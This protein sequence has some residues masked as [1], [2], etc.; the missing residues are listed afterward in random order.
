MASE[1]EQIK[2]VRTAHVNVRELHAVFCCAVILL[3]W[4][5]QEKKIMKT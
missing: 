5:F 2:D 1:L 4:I 3:K